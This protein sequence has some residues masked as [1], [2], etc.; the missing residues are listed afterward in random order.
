[1]PD[2]LTPRSTSVTEKSL[3]CEDSEVTQLWSY[4][5]STST[6]NVISVP[7][8][9]L[10]KL[11]RT[12]RRKHQFFVYCLD[13]ASR[14]WKS[15]LRSW[16]MAYYAPVCRSQ[17]ADSSKDYDMHTMVQCPYDP[18]HIVQKRKFPAHLRKCAN[19]SL[20]NTWCS[21]S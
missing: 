4:L 15:C 11:T 5:C 13:I 2:Y 1:M 8:A 12:R 18:V 16:E 17:M 20:K 9:R 6:T 14:L 19:V 10:N 7:C 3:K 21:N